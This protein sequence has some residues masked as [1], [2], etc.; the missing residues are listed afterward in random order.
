MRIRII[1]IC[2]V[3]WSCNYMLFMRIVYLYVWC[4]LVRKVILYVD[5]VF[6]CEW[7]SIL[8]VYAHH[9][10]VY[11]SLVL[12][13]LC[14]KTA[15]N[16]KC[17]LHQRLDCNTRG[18]SYLNLWISLRQQFQCFTFNF[19]HFQFHLR[20]CHIFLDETLKVH[21]LFHYYTVSIGS[22]YYFFH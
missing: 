15:C 19:I 8:Y 18:N 10:S 12:L 1:W 16:W 20:K 11:E 4:V 13:N 22:M 5:C 9:V 17:K 3:S 2:I 14:Y 6:F 21:I 7:T